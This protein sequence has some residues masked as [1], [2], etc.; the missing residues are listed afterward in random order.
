[1][2][3]RA[4]AIS[5]YIDGFDG[6]ASRIRVALSTDAAGGSLDQNE[7]FRSDVVDQVL[8][9]PEKASIELLVALYRALTFHSA[10]AWGADPRMEEIGKQMLIRGGRSVARD[11][12]TGAA[13]SFDAL[14][15]T[16]F[17]DC[18]RAVAE[19]CL[20]Y[21]RECLAAAGDEDEKALWTLG[22]ERFEALLQHAA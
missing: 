18:P 15:A 22:V 21:A 19:V 6:D 1:M 2:A 17:V 3:D 8:A 9:A 10:E 4:A 16:S 20:G 13:Q 5:A 11:Y 7:A 12:V 14:C